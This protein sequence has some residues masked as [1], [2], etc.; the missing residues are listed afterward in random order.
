MSDLKPCIRCGTPKPLIERC[1]PC[2]S[3]QN[4]IDHAK[5]KARNYKLVE[6]AES[7]RQ[8]PSTLAVRAWV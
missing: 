5:R 2:K 3:I 8:L 7:P 4:K 1:K 6:N